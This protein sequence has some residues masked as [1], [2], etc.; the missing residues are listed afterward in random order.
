METAYQYCA[1]I[2]GTVIVCQ[3][4]L[5]LFGLGGDHDTG[6]HD[7]GGHDIGGHDVGHDVAHDPHHG[8]GHTSTNWLFGVLTLRTIVAG[9]AFFGLTGLILMKGGV[10]ETF[11][12]VGAIAA[13]LAA[14]V[15]VSWLMR[16]LGK[17]NVDGTIT[18][19]R[20]LGATGTVYLSIPGHKAGSGKVHVSINNRLVE[21]K[22]ITTQ[23]DLPTGAKVV[24]V[25]IVSSDTVEV[26]PVSISEGVAHA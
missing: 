10:D 12:L 19:D 6:G 24:V 17:L 26:N 16:S 21:Y 9:L 23:E 8:P 15:L 22:A 18:I 11:T 20:A 5:T 13:G 25:G 2:G 4:L 14:L 3:F 1:I 7:V